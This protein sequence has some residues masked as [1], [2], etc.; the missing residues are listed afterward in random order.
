MPRLGRGDRRAQSSAKF[1]ML[2]NDYFCVK[3]F[4]KL[5]NNAFVICHSARHHHG[6]EFLNA[7]RERFCFYRNALVEAVNNIRNKA[8][9]G[10]Q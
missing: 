5:G 8:A 3:L 4:F 1:R 6:A 7:P 9:V 10:D 2:R